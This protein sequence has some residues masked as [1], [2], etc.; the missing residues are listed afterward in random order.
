MEIHTA[1]YVSVS[2]PQN[3]FLKKFLRMTSKNFW[4]T[5]SF[6]LSNALWGKEIHNTRLIFEIMLCIIKMGDEI[7]FNNN[8]HLTGKR[9]H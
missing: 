8:H 2:M 1:F 7:E 4:I 6:W 9:T 3:G 5:L